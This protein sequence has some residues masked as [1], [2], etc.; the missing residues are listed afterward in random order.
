MIRLAGLAPISARAQLGLRQRK[1]V[2]PPWKKACNLV[3]LGLPLSHL[4]KRYHPRRH[5]GA[6]GA[7][8][9]I[10]PDLHWRVHARHRPLP[11]A[12]NVEGLRRSGLALGDVFLEILRD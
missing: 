2:Q 10:P 4:F 6:D 5:R 1:A 11:S 12:T 3:R 8:A 7:P 9:I